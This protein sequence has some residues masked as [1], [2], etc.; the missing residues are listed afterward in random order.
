M[1][2]YRLLPHS[3]NITTYA[4]GIPFGGWFDWVSCPHFFFEIFIYFSLYCALEGS[5]RLF[6]WLLA[7]VLLN[8]VIA[9]L[10]THAWYLDR[11]KHTYP[12]QRKAIFPCLL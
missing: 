4:H 3:G 7:F 11:F 2:E 1:V 12:A 10:I 9:A 5:H 6:L 8:Q